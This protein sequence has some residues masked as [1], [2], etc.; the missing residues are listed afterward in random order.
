MHEYQVEHNDE[1]DVPQGCKS[2]CTILLQG[3]K[4]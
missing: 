4:N 2:L 1:G 3:N